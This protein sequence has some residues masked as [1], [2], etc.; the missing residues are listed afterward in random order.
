MTDP[1][2][3]GGSHSTTRRGLLKAAG[4]ASAGM[5]AARLLSTG[6]VATPADPEETD[7]TP[8]PS[9]TGDY[10]AFPQSVASGDPTPSGAIV[11]TRLDSELAAF[12][13]DDLFL[14]VTAAPDRTT[15]NEEADFAG[16]DTYRV[17][18]PVADHDYTVSV[19][20]DGELDADR[21]YFYRFVYGNRVASPVGRL[22]TLPEPDA[23]PDRLSLAV[24]SC[25]R[26]E[27]GYFGGFA[28]IAEEDVDYHVS[29][30]DFLYEYAGGGSQPGRDI[31]LPSGKSVAHTLDDFR[32]LHQRYRS[33]EHLQAAM[34]RHTFIHTWDDHEVVNNRWW[35]YEA[36]APNTASHPFG[37]DFEQM[38]QLYAAGIAG[39]L[40]YLPLR[41]AYE[42][43]DTVGPEK[44]AQDYFRLYRSFKFGDLTELFMT[45]ER[46]YRS[47]PPEDEA[48]QRDV[49][50]PPSR[51]QDD[52]DRSML[53]TEQYRWFLDGG[54]NPDGL[55]DTEG[56]T[57]TDAQWKLHGNEVLC[58]ALR[59]AGAGPASVYLNYDA[60]DG[61]EAERNLIM[62][63]LAKDEVENY[64]TLTGDMHTYIAGYLKQDYKDPEQ[65]EYAGGDRVG[66]EFMTPGVTSDNLAA[67]GGLP[68]GETEDAIDESIQLQ[69]PHIEWFNSSRWGYTTV[70]ITRSGLV[71]TAYEV[72]R[73]VDSADAP[74]R[75]LRSYRVP[76]GRYELQEFRSPPLDDVIGDRVAASFASDDSDNDPEDGG[77]NTTRGDSDGGDIIDDAVTDAVSGF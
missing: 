36:D 19:D 63:R 43:P 17:P 28:R 32:H 57:G 4:A 35:N 6:A 73:S 74:K 72:D 42:D 55:P 52:L 8:A 27:H 40:E 1:T 21:F 23:S 60:W 10:G 44:T 22:R 45:D 30:G 7:E 25:N 5:A 76:N 48:G 18:D 26:Y 59:S 70:D 53:G 51:K 11:W 77:S 24:S 2:G 65:S 46:L 56:V 33:D 41:V 38:R 16:A 68:A 64:V 3:D 20:L 75:L 31:Q 66:I 15:A 9:A 37:G 39:M 12:S 34:E 50:V 69:N 14:Q 47:P 13:D 71:Y 54:P 62:G 58:A 29:L 61:Y 49:A 67:A